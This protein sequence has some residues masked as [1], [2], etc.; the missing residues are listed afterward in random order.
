[1]SPQLLTFTTRPFMG[2]THVTPFFHHD[3]R[4]GPPIRMTPRHCLSNRT[5]GHSLNPWEAVH[6]DRIGNRATY[7]VRN[8]S[9]DKD[10]CRHTL[11][12]TNILET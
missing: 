9:M 7:P 12:K 4:G 6:R 1:M 3:R 5:K 2:K 10:D 8:K 11:P